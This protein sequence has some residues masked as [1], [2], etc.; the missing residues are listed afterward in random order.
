MFAPNAP[1]EDRNIFVDAITS[2]GRHVDPLNER[3]SRVAPAGTEVIP[4][5]L[6]Q[7][8]FFCDYMQR[9][10]GQGAYHPPLSEW[11]Q[12]YHERTGRP[13]DRITSFEVYEIVDQSPPPG[14]TQPTDSKRTLLFSWPSLQ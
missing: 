9:I 5:Y 3:G 8:E 2:D 13:E 14:Q 1:T 11:I 4:E 7:D 10:G 12:A 6:H